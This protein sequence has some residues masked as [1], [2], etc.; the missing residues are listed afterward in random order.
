MM[1]QRLGV[2]GDVHA[3]DQRLQAALQFFAE[4]NVD[5]VLCTG[6]I[7]DGAGNV[8]RCCQLLNEHAIDTVRG[9]HDRWFLNFQARDLP[10][11]NDWDE[12]SF[13]SRS[14]L[15]SL[16]P[17]RAYQTVAGS[18]LLCHGVGT[19]DMQFLSADDYGYAL[20]CKDEL[21]QLVRAREFRFMIGGH[22]H[23]RMVR[24]YQ[25]LIVI[26]AGTLKREQQ[27]C[28]TLIDFVER[29]VQFYE[30]NALNFSPTDSIVLDTLP[31][32][33]SLVPEEKPG[34]LRWWK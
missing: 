27:P 3:E 28:L 6:D 22:T 14:W 9:N 5:K 32:A 1:L 18:L 29:I 34:I 8:E 17:T 33:F 10:D 25:E 30:P 2:I 7:V 20:Q 21:Q 19:N 16:P 11:A 13:A 4:R 31:D 26:N 23:R 15:W 12:L 24:R